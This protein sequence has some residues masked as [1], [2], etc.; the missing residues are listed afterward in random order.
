[1]EIDS[2]SQN[3]HPVFCAKLSCE[4]SKD[5]SENVAAPTLGQAGVSCGI[6]PSRAVGSGEDGV[7]TLEYHVDIPTASHLSRDIQA[8]SLDGGAS[9]S[10]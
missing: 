3:A 8:I 5:A 4:G 6:H 1:M 7:K 9:G 2:Q 10:E